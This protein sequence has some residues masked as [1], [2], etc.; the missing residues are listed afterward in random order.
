MVMA[1]VI[2]R[3]RLDRSLQ[4]QLMDEAEGLLEV[5]SSAIESVPT[6]AISNAHEAARKALTA[7]IARNGYRVTAKDRH[8]A[9]IDYAKARPGFIDTK[10]SAGLD[11]LRRTRNIVQ[12]PEDH[13]RSGRVVLDPEG[14]VD[15][16][17]RL[18]NRVSKELAPRIPPPP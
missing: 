10:T 11:V 2:T 7:L 13:T 3:E 15:L 18:V 16:A 6:A 5:A 4:K 9:T 12:Y 17:R 14:S 1:G 8:A